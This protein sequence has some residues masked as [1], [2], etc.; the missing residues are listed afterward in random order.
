MNA[1]GP[2]RVFISYS[3]DSAKHT[4]RVRQL[5]DA[6]RRDGVDC[7]LDQYIHP[8][9]EGWAEWCE[10]EIRGADFVILVI[11]GEYQR[12]VTAQPSPGPGR[13]S[14]WEFDLVR[15]L[16]YL[17]TLDAGKLLTVVF[18]Q[19]D[20]QHVESLLGA[21]HHYLVAGT[22][23]KDAGYEKL[24][25]RLTDQPDVPLPELGSLKAL[26]LRQRQFDI[27]ELPDVDRSQRGETV[28]PPGNGSEKSDDQT[29]PENKPGPGEHV[30]PESGVSTAV[31]L[32]RNPV[33]SALSEPQV[34]ELPKRQ[35]GRRGT[36]LS[37]LAIAAACLAFGA[38][39]AALS[40]PKPTDTGV[41]NPSAGGESGKSEG[42]QISQQSLALLQDAT[43][44]LERGELDQ[45]RLQFESVTTHAS[46]LADGY[47]GLARVAAA[48][49]KWSNAL[50]YLDEALTRDDA[51]WPGYVFR[52]KLL[53]MEAS[54]TE[55]ELAAE[56]EAMRGKDDKL[57]Q[58]I[59]CFL[60]EGGVSR[61][62][63]SI[64]GIGAACNSVEYVFPTSD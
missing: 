21:A 49:K 8:P 41:G 26:P 22:S 23:F 62:Y 39:V 44:A 37:A 13:G 63:T 3:H 51:F 6:L 16:R 19:Q 64:N 1:S 35:A 29:E 46:H 38:G 57:D 43:A 45:A 32:E 61:I 31:P 40:R 55:S 60:K 28:S 18:S 59:E 5:A 2:K 7:R 12:R 34:G 42:P 30:D 9:G 4:E 47:F 53:M 15:S 36:F 10:K 17:R 27:W 24:Y 33:E 56:I 52:I 20:Q 58:W 11:T 14:R 25:R 48:H 50:D 54:L